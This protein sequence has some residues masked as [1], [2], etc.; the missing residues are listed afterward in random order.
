MTASPMNFSIVPP[1]R[2]S[3]G[4]HRVEVA[5]HHLAQRLRVEPLAE[6]GRPLQ[7]A[8][9]DRDGLANLLLG[10]LGRELAPQNP[11]SRNRAGSPHRNWGRFA[12]VRVYADGSKTQGAHPVVS[13]VERRAERVA[14]GPELVERSGLA[15]L[16]KAEALP[17]GVA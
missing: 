10:L 12:R 9:D 1:C 14:E 5:G 13:A 2:S 6:R 7:V 11:Q 17:S 8:E 4:A 3:D 15:D 16:G